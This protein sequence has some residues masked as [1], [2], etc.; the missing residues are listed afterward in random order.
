MKSVI[1][2][3]ARYVC[4]GFLCMA[5]GS[6][7]AQYD[8]AQNESSGGQGKDQRSRAKIHTEL[9]SLYF[10]AGNPGVALDHLATALSADSSYYEAYSVRGLVHASLRE[11]AKAQADFTKAL[12]YAPNDPEVNNNYGWFL[13]DTGKARES[14]PY[15]MTALKNPLYKTPDRAYANAG[16]CALKAG[17]LD[18]A[19]G[20][21][22]N[23][24]QFAQDGAPAA[25]Y[26]M[27]RLLYQ[28]KNFDEARVYL[29]EF[30][31]VQKSPSAEALWLG[32]RLERRL[33]NRVAESGHAAQLRGRYPTSPE[34][35]EFLKGNFE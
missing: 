3:F 8:W 31:S 19:Q 28:R 25:R 18:A 14:I 22:L 17:D 4:C 33:G 10:Q 27:A 6:A 16:M 2:A 35:Q 5:A 13:C 30:F 34:Y 26:Y 1:S 21:L 23:A 9:G 11:I 24:I 7:W 29:N 15:F 20:Y 32:V 12:D